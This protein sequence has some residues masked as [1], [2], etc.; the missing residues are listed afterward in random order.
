MSEV[1]T[2]Y[3]ERSGDLAHA[4]AEYLRQTGKDTD[5]VAATD[6]GVI[7]ELHIGGRPATIDVGGR[8]QLHRD[9]RVL[10]VGSGLGGPARTLAETY[11]CHVTGIDLTPEFCDA[12]AVLSAWVGLEDRVGFRQG[13]ATDM[14]FADD[15]FD[16]AMTIH[17]AMNIP[18]KDAVYAEVRRVLKPGGR[19]V[20]YD[21][22]KE[23]G[24][25][26]ALP[27]PWA[28]T[29]SINHLVTL[30]DMRFLLT[31]AGFTIVEIEDR[32]DRS[33][34]FFEEMARSSRAGRIP[35]ASHPIFG[36]DM[37]RMGANMLRNLREEKIRTF[38]FVCE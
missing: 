10:D 20:V 25:E 30:E 32:S 31:G 19:F 6:L 15:A 21:V 5:R 13:D 14:P 16:A 3:S 27:V 33:L 29:P 34:G 12:A 36:D 9:S 35:R 38:M 28:R 17:V 26:I 8:M 11:G 23:G 1:A 22:L 24:G 4:I 7:D 2:R 37:P 18:K